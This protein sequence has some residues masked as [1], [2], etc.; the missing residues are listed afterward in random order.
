MDVMWHGHCVWDQINQVLLQFN[1]LAL[2]FSCYVV[3]GCDNDKVVV[4]ECSSLVNGAIHSGLWCT[5]IL[6]VVSFPGFTAVKWHH[7]LH[8]EIK[9]LNYKS[10]W[11]LGT[12]LDVDV[13]N[14]YVQFCTVSLWKCSRDCFLKQSSKKISMHGFLFDNFEQNDSPSLWKNCNW[15]ITAERLLHKTSVL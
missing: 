3:T 10:V 12:W 15:C 5:V 11:F 1:L 9:C 4:L 14:L 6:F 7:M 13:Q 2:W 8:S